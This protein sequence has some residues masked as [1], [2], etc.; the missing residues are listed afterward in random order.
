ML[1]HIFPMVSIRSRGRRVRGGKGDSISP[2]ISVCF[3]AGFL[4]PDAE[5]PLHEEGGECDASPTYCA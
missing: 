5:E 3:V 4:L 1:S 2:C